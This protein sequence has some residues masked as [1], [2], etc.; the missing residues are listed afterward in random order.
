MALIKCIECGKEVSDKAEVCVHCG[1][2]LKKEK[3]KDSLK[4]MK[5]YL[6]SISKDVSEIR[7]KII[8]RPE[9]HYG[10]IKIF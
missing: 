6:E 5:E 2:P 7:N 1:Y 8:D 9:Y 4:E 10:G 3:T